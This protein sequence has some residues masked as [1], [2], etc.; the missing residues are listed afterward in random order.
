MIDILTNAGG[1]FYLHGHVHDYTEYTE[2]NGAIVVNEVASLGK[3]DEANIGV[4]AID[5]NGFVY[6]AT[7]VTAP[8]PFVMITTP[9]SVVLRGGA[10]PNPYAYFVC[11]DRVDNPFRALVFAPAPPSEVTI[12]VEGLSPFPMKPVPGSTALWE[13]EIDTTSLAATVLDVTVS[14]TAG[15][16]TR[17]ETITAGFSA[18]PCDPLPGG[19]GGSG[20]AGGAGRRDHRRRGRRD[21]RRIGRRD[22]GGAGGALAGGAG[23]AIPTRPEAA[24]AG[25]LVMIRRR[26]ARPVALGALALMV[27]RARRR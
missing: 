13:A 3:N 22:G 17:A 4:G 26:G 11:K 27:R 24:G 21:H 10:E 20:G 18:G 2:G 23:G 12:T 7:D 8:W 14:A 5:N 15:G 1:A 25:R 16:V 9:T 6:R 19:E